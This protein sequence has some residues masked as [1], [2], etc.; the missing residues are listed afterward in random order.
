MYFPYLHMWIL[1]QT[2]DIKKDL[3]LLWQNIILFRIWDILM[4]YFM[5]L[6]S[7]RT[8]GMSTGLQ[9]SFFKLGDCFCFFTGQL[10]PS[11]SSTSGGILF[12]VLEYPLMLHF[13]YRKIHLNVTF[14]LQEV[15]HIVIYLKNNLSGRDSC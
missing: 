2:L 13:K 1:G 6:K 8:I 9:Y 4:D 7:S 11:Y 3:M 12:K 5:I 10:H 14:F 15:I